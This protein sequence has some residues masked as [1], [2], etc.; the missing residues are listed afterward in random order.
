M[1]KILYP[2]LLGEMAKHGD[3]KGKL[4]EYLGVT[5]TTLYTRFIGKTEWTISEIERICKRYNKDYYQLF[6]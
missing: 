2:E 4:C 5:R 1:K 6:K 3:T